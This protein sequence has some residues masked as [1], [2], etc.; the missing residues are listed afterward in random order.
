MHETTNELIQN[1]YI[2]ANFVVSKQRDNIINNLCMT[3]TQ[4]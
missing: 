3:A 2:V 1:N 4:F